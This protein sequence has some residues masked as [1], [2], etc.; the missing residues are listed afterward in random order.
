MDLFGLDSAQSNSLILG[1]KEGGN[2]LSSY[3]IFEQGQEISGADEYN[4]NLAIQEGDFDVQN[5]DTQETELLSTQRALYTKAGV[6]LSGSALD[7]MLKSAT[8]AEMDKSVANFN[9]Q[10][11]ANEYDYQAKVAKAQAGF[12]SGENL[13]SGGLKILSS[14]IKL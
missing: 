8:Q 3:G 10:S 6:A 5:L 1:L 9:A 12:K 13:I 11:K 2:L 14:A 4:A 7:V